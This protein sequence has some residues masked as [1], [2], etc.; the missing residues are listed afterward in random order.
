M[1]INVS[2]D[3]S[4]DGAPAAFKAVINSVVAFF[5]STFRDPVTVTI[6]VGYGEIN[7]QAMNAGSLGQSLTLLNRYSYS[8]I[9]S[10]LA[11][12]AKSADDSSAVASLPA[13]DPTGGH[14]WVA[15]AEAKA[16][17]L[18]SG[19]G[20][21]GYVGFS[22]SASFDYDN[23]NGVTGY[24]FYGVV[25][26]ELSEVMGRAM[27]VGRTI[28]TTTNG[29]YPMDLL[30]FSAPGVH[31]FAGN[32]A[33][34]FS[35]DNG[36]TNLDSFNTSS[37]GDPGDWAS[38]AGSDAFRAFSSSGV[39]NAITPTDLRLMDA[40]GWDVD[41][42]L[43]DLT[44]A[45]LAIDV[46]N[47]S[48]NV[49]NVGSG[50]AGSSTTG[51][52][53]SSNG[54]ITP[55]DILLATVATPSLASGAIDDESVA[56]VLPDSLAAGTYY[57]GAYADSTAEVAESSNTNNAS[58]AIA[59]ILGNTTGNVLTGTSADDLMFGFGGN[60]TL[61]G[62]AGADTMA[63]GDGNDVY[64]V[65]N[66]LDAVIENPGEGTDTIKTLVAGYSLPDNVEN[67]TYTGVGSF[68]GTGNA[69]AN[70]ITGGAFGNMLSGADGN[71]V[72]NGGA[73]PDTLS[74]GTGNDK[75]YGQGGNDTLIG[76]NGNDTLNGGLGA[77]SMAGGPGND[78]YYVDNAL[79]VVTENAGEG[80][81][82][83]NTTL[84]RYVLP[85]NLEKLNYTG[86]GNFTGTGN[87]TA[88]TITGGPGNDVLNGGA[89]NDTLR[90]GTGADILNGNGGND[91]LDGGGGYD[92]A[93][94]GSGADD[95]VFAPTD[96][97][98]GPALGEIKDFSGSELD[99]IDIS[100]MDAIAGGVDNPFSFI[101]AHSFSGVA[102]QLHYF[103]NAGGG[104]TVEGDLNGDR[105]ADFS[106][107]V[108]GVSSLAA[109]DFI[110]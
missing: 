72:L 96:L 41:A 83:V 73:G 46:T 37:G 71:D 95:F 108:D 52:Y 106:I 24:D 104:I 69:L 28:G 97:N 17:G 79:D 105:V 19:A 60:D 66:A 10:A 36:A 85:A 80:T 33:G 65:D 75:L 101:G 15:Q 32:Q 84:A 74:G 107:V 94:G 12:D 78:T 2:Y 61:D 29:Y 42:P 54:N 67:L 11:A 18:A 92:I 70:T 5:D 3:S 102:G 98:S 93:T 63:G 38:S 43:P 34:Y 55:S 88:D 13:S 27:L 90:G 77:D 35:L 59:V 16:L 109:G 6:D 44:I 40:I 64:L 81:D 68:A 49:S 100:A 4:V 23:S 89:G 9:K 57:I 31:S 14:Y 103:A 26:H 91:R 25:A 53:L 99:Q 56:V 47:V 22:S 82:T 58:N 50:A 51:I 62:G 1:I 20:L 86:T 48:Y 110:L 30:H 21:D 87:P 76:G 45:N 39:V 7:T 8:Q